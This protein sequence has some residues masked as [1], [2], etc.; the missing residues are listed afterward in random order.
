MSRACLR[1]PRAQNLTAVD[2]T[3]SAD[4][5][6][7]LFVQNRRHRLQYADGNH[8][9]LQM[10]W[11]VC[12]QDLLHESPEHLSNW[13]RLSQQILK[14]RR[15]TVTPAT[16]PIMPL[17]GGRL[18]RSFNVA[19]FFTMK[20]LTI[21]GVNPATIARTQSALKMKQ[22]QQAKESK[23]TMAAKSR[24]IMP[25]FSEAPHVESVAPDI[26]APITRSTSLPIRARKSQQAREDQFH[27]PP[28]GNSDS[29]IN[30]TPFSKTESP[31]RDSI[32]HIRA[33]SLLTIV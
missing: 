30:S 8:E 15:F 13:Q 29:I 1:L 32:V 20:A 3:G 7:S 27:A 14:L 5:L 18:D 21:K 11:S 12:C 24:W 19:M 25:S 23:H 2:T 9:S 26:L 22:S 10:D 6:F 28:L 33:T 16:V 4:R 31:S 17:F